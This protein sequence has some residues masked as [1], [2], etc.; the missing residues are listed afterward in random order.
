MTVQKNEGLGESEHLCLGRALLILINEGMLRNNS[1]GF[2][3]FA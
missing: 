3:M 1:H 2:R